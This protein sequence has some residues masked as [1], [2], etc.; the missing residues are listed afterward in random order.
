MDLFRGAVFDHGGNARK[1]PISL[2]R[3]FPSLMGHFPPLM[4]RFPPQCLNGPFFL[5]KIPWKGPWKGSWLRAQIRE[6]QARTKL[7]SPY[8]VAFA[9][10]FSPE[11]FLDLSGDLSAIVGITL[12]IVVSYFS[13]PRSFLPFIHTNRSDKHH[14]QL[15]LQFIS[16]PEWEPGPTIVKKKRD[17]LRLRQRFWI[18]REFLGPKMRDFL[19]INNCW[20]TA[21]FS[22][23]RMVKLIPTE[24][25]PATPETAV[26]NR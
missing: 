5:S 9:P 22:A 23:I 25:T 26:Q 21:S 18:P 16:T 20:R 24:G 15:Q 3:P 19:G 8:C 14:T 2:N 11:S 1:Q 12:R 6:N 4:C 7:R 13:L 10:L 17:S